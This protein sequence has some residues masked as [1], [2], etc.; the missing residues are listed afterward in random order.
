[1]I[2]FLNIYIFL[3]FYYFECLNSLL[4]Q[5]VP[6]YLAFKEILP[7]KYVRV[8]AQVKRI[9]FSG[10]VTI[11]IMSEQYLG[12]KPNRPHIF[13]WKH[14]FYFFLNKKLAEIK[15]AVTTI[16]EIHMHFFRDLYAKLSRKKN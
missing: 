6:Y 16:I 1:M 14:L 11:I 7:G 8:L 3:F 10:L 2:I 13:S 12:V 15:L 9:T 5:E 4:Q